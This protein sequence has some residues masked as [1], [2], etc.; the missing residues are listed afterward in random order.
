MNF[1]YKI[2]LYYS[3]NIFSDSDYSYY[4]FIYFLCFI[5]LIRNNISRCD[6]TD[7]VEKM[8]N[9]TIFVNLKIMSL[10]EV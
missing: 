3:F 6:F 4:I 8:T 7:A 9:R 5:N 1:S 2:T 10:A